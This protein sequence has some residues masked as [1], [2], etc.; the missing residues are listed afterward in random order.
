[1]NREDVEELT[2]VEQQLN[3]ITKKI[4]I[5]DDDDDDN[6]WRKIST[7]TTTTTTKDN[8]NILFDFPSLPQ[9]PNMPASDGRISPEGS[10]SSTLSLNRTERLSQDNPLKPIDFKSFRK[11]SCLLGSPVDDKLK[12]SLAQNW[13]RLK[14]L[15]F[16]HRPSVFQPTSTWDC[17]NSEEEEE[18][19]EDKA[20]M[21][22][23]HR[24]AIDGRGSGVLTPTRSS[25]PP[26]PKI[27]KEPKIL[28]ANGYHHHDHD[29]SAN[30]RG[31]HRDPGYSG[32][33]SPPPR[34]LL[35][36]L[37][38][39]SSDARAQHGTD[40]PAPSGRPNLLR[41]FRDR[42]TS[43]DRSFHLGTGFSR[44]QVSDSIGGRSATRP[45]QMGLAPAVVRDPVQKTYSLDSNR[46]SGPLMRAASLSKF[47]DD[48]EF[49]LSPPTVT[50]AANSARPETGRRFA[51]SG[52]FPFPPAVDDGGPVSPSSSSSS[53]SA[54]SPGL[55]SS[56]SLLGTRNAYCFA[57]GGST[58]STP[59]PTSITAAGL[60]LTHRSSPIAGPLSSPY[61]TLRLQTGR[62]KSLTRKETGM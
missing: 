28:T 34:V 31:H 4:I 12:P 10:S 61:A 45:I 49:L 47:D 22:P 19:K 55:L 21:L 46:S 36:S 18:D 41:P 53:S 13:E 62:T 11:G 30:M 54:F 60:G 7:T 38:R 6:V 39:T 57:H 43:G 26:G 37:G 59:T 16:H 23:A 27:F 1:M 56:S 8:E 2:S 58:S 25:P 44:R 42:G 17:N 15:S 3:E 48:D 40:P 33:Q 14:A 51:G 29:Q 35:A 9:P 20:K 24:S 5:D 52:S 32:P 50:I